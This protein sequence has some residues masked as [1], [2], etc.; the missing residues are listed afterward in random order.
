MRRAGD[1]AGMGLMGGG[2]TVYITELWRDTEGRGAMFN[3]ALDGPQLGAIALVIVGAVVL[4]ERKDWGARN[5]A[6]NV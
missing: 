3:G 5:E 1:L 6:G 2:V 4:L